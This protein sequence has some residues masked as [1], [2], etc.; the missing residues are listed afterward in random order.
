MEVY[1][2]NTL[3]RKLELLRSFQDT[4]EPI[5]MYCCGPTVYNYP[6]IGNMR[7]YIFEDLLRRGLEYL[8]YKTIHVMNITD[9]GH[10]SDDGDEGEDKVVKAAREKGMSVKDIALYFEDV[11]FQYSQDLNILRPHYTPRATEEVETMIRDISLLIKKGFA[12]ESGGNVYF[13]VKK[14]P[15]YYDLSGFD[16]SNLRIS[17][18]GSDP[19]KKDSQDF[20][21]WF[22][23][24]KFNNQSLLWDSPWGKGY[25]GWHI[26]C[27]AMARKILGN[28]IDIH[29]GGVDH[30]RVHHT[31]EKAQAESLT[32]EPW[33][34]I[35]MH[36]EFLVINEDK[37]SKSKNNFLTM[38]TLQSKGFSPLDYRYLCL[39]THYRK[40]LTFNF[41]IL[42]AAR[43]ARLKLQ[44]AFKD[45][46]LV[47]SQS[48]NVSSKV[49]LYEDSFKKTISQDLGIPKALSLVWQVLKDDE[50]SKK[51]K[52]ILI[53]R[54]DEVFGLKLSEVQLTDNKAIISQEWEDLLK[55]REKAKKAKDFQ[56]ADEIRDFFQKKGYKVV[57]A[58]EGSYLEFIDSKR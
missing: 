9:V 28:K 41:D 43:T 17:R 16:E 47:D 31:N 48:S 53:Q 58:I 34:Q 23:H 21:L 54:W 19:L 30:I 49:E 15:Q 38:E 37:M 36:S 50:I 55:L 5:R 8:G 11:F 35:W 2:H 39:G 45:L 18:V 4:L 32:K 10:L 51:D 20:A 46:S 1:L 6:H 25:M 40:Q 52:K 24:S 29:C 33:V 7:T 44:K 12:Y 3:T 14:F 22:T 13:S 56:K 27:S 42:K 57:D 26:E